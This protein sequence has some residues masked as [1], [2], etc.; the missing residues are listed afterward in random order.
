MTEIW[1]RPVVLDGPDPIKEQQ[2]VTVF[3]WADVRCGSCH[4]RIEPGEY[5]VPGRMC[6]NP[7]CKNPA[8]VT[9]RNTGGA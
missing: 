7:T 5:L 8:H 1:K 3:E 2:R 6:N 4:Q 9:E